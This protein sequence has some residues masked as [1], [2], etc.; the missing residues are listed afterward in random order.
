MG[1]DLAF[2]VDSD[3]EGMAVQPSTFMTLWNMR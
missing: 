2:K 3:A 1:I